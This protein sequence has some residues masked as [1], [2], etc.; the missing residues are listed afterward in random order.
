MKR[1]KVISGLL[2]IMFTVSIFG[3]ITDG[4]DD[5][6]EGYKEGY[7]ERK[8][9]EEQGICVRSLYLHLKNKKGQ[10]Y[11]SEITNTL[12]N[13]TIPLQINA[14]K[15]LIPYTSESLPSWLSIYENILIISIIFIFGL[16]FAIPVL[17]YF[18]I[19]S[20]VKGKILEQKNIK[21]CRKLGWFI[22]FIYIFE[23]LTQSLEY[24]KAINLVD[25]SEY[26]L[27]WDY[28]DFPLLFLGLTILLVAEILNVSL[29]MKEEQEL[30]I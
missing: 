14:A 24:L 29:K 1:I 5:F 17:S 11:P 10:L 19:I 25:F 2:A 28:F 8:I 6:I 21:R 30:T 15:T 7:N 9:M 3:L 12:T 18:I 23:L 13:Q 4:F 22:V 27:K 20:A 26:T 16:L